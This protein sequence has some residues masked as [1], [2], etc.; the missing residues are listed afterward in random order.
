MDE[1]VLHH[2]HHH[3]LA[4]GAL[5]IVVEEFIASRHH[6]VLPPS[7][8]LSFSLLR[9]KLVGRHKDPRTNVV[10]GVLL[11]HC[12]YFDVLYYLVLRTLCLF[13]VNN[14]HSILKYIHFIFDYDHDY[15]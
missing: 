12:S 6:Q 3:H 2:H 5:I 9:Q 8:Y 14:V 7:L 1:H 11:V 15:I 10:L 13:L 4:L